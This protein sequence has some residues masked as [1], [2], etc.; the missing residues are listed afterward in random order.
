[1][2]GFVVHSAICHI[3]RFYDFH[4]WAVGGWQNIDSIGLG[5]RGV[6]G[7]EEEVNVFAL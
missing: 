7:S 5:G 2:D 3:D 1:M 4:K 6:Y